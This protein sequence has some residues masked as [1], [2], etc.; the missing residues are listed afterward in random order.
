MNDFVLPE[1]RYAISGDVNIAYQVMGSGPVD[2]VMVPGVVSHCEFMHELPGYTAFVR[3]LSTLPASSLLT[4][5]GRG[6]PIEFRVRHPS[7]NAWMTSARSWMTSVRSG[8][9]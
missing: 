1:T 5:E 8:R 4:K 7:S 6:Y 2:I 9:Q 3:R